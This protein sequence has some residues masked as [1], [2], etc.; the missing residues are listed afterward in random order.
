M[1]HKI[2]V[3]YTQ[4]KKWCKEA[5]IT[6]QITFHCSRHTA[7]TLFL[8]LGTTIEVTSKLLGHTKISTT[9]QYTKIVNEAQRAAVEKQN[10]IFTIIKNQ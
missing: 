2:I 8:T 4:L 1:Q 3:D 7:A 9:Q 10:N 5:K 6:K